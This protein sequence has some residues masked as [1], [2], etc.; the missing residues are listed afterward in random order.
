VKATET[1]AATDIITGLAVGLES[2]AFP[3]LIVAAAILVSVQFAPAGLALYCIA[4]AGVGM[5]ATLGITLSVDAYG[6]VADNAGGIA[7]MSHQE[8]GVRA[9]TDTL[10]SVGNTTAAIGKGFAIGGAALTALGLVVA[11]TQAVKLPLVDLLSPVVF[12]GVLVGAMLPFVFCSFSMTAVGKA[13]GEIVQEV[14]RQ[15]KEIP[16]LM[17]GTAEP[18]YTACITIST[19]AALRQ[20]IAPGLMAILAPLVVGK[21]LGTAAL[22]GLL[23]GS[24]ASGFIVAIMMANAGGAWDNTKKYI[25]QGHL[26]GK[27]SPAHMAAVTGDTVGDPFKDTAGPA[28]NILI[29]LMAIV[30]VVFAPLFL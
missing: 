5:L 25:E 17:E 22:A 3:V 12:V 11:Y 13:A 14:R 30:S 23:V 10:D 16:G 21:L 4:I 1:G 18:D 27:G 8:K 2:T 9:I 19:N 24:I 28:L 15:F 6:P 7:E 29:K 20:M 26:G